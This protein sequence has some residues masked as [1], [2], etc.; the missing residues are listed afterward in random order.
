MLLRAER[1][2]HDNG[3]VYR[4]AY[5]VSDGQGEICSGTAKVSVPRGNKAAI[6]DGDATSYDSFTGAPVP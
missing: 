6:D 2:G 3:R 4:I 5:D 1:S